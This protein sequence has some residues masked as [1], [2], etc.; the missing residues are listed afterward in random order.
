MGRRAWEL[1]ELI[2][3]ECRLWSSTSS[4]LDT[5]RTSTR[6]L[7]CADSDLGLFRPKMHRRPQTSRLTST[8]VCGLFTTDTAK[9]GS[10]S[11]EYRTT[12]EPRIFS[13]R[14]P[15]YTGLARFCAKNSFSPTVRTG[16]S[17]RFPM[18]PETP[19]LV[20]PLARGNLFPR[21]CRI[22]PAKRPVP[23]R[24][25]AKDSMRQAPSTLIL[26]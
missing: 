26:Q 4:R 6:L 2:E 10:Q 13:R 20:R 15:I 1:E 3:F 18:G 22:L 12:S 24:R 21:R 23:P 9:S 14:G 17:F 11:R 5:A 19:C 16:P 25:S 7:L 8:L